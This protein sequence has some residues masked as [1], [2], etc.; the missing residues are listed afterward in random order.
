MLSNMLQDMIDPQVSVFLHKGYLEFELFLQT[1]AFLAGSPALQ[2]LGLELAACATAVS[3]LNEY[4]HEHWCL[5]QPHGEDKIAA[6]PPLLS[7]CCCI[8]PSCFISYVLS[9]S[10]GFLK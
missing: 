6:P 3:L 2:E 1:A 7:K 8:V 4:L 9:Q 10:V 5:L